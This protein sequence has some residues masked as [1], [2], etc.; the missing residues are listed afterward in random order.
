[1]PLHVIGGEW[2]GRRLKSPPTGPRPSTAIVK[3]S[4]FDILGPGIA[5]K[6]VL[7]LYSGTGQLG[8]EALSRGAARCDMVERDAASARLLA[9]NLRTLGAE[10]RARVHSA[11]VETWIARHP[12]EIAEFDLV[13]ADPPYG[14]P[15]V[16]AVLEALGE[17]MKPEAMLVVEDRA[18]RPHA[19]TSLDEVRRVRHGGSALTFFRPAPRPAEPGA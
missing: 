6:R 11:A 19:A 8:I 14:D 3:R 16:P 7:D 4:L 12:G 15:G 1:L 13:I 10:A 2:R 17:R 5:G 18:G 9:D